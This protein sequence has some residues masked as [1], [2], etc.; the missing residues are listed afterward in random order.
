M[1]FE[2]KFTE[3]PC[4]FTLLFFRILFLSTKYETHKQMRSSSPCGQGGWSQPSLHRV[5]LGMETVLVFF[6]IGTLFICP[7][8]SALT[9]ATRSLSTGNGLQYATAGVL[10]QFTVTVFEENGVHRTSG[11][12][13][14]IVELAGTRS[15]QGSVIDNLDGSYQ[16]TY[17]G[18]K[19]GSYE[20]SV[21]LLRE[22]GLVASYFENVCFFYTPVLV[23]V[24]PQINHDWV[25]GMLTPTA[26][27]YVSVRWQGR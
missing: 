7:A 11:G 13:D 27:D 4:A 8:I 26:T 25:T 10:A 19:S 9:D 22:G 17:T 20:V 5:T 24:D 16:T 2:N 18:T 15:A 23:A 14:F 3:N 6:V 12:D 1:V 21:K